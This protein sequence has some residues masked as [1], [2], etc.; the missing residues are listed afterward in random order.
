M[1]PLS[2][3]LFF[4][5]YVATYIEILC[6]RRYL[7]LDFL[8]TVTTIRST[9]C[10]R[11]RLILQID[12]EI[13]P[14]GPTASSTTTA[15]SSS[16]SSLPIILKEFD[17]I[18][19]REYVEATDKDQVIQIFVDGMLYAASFATTKALKAPQIFLPILSWAAVV[20]SKVFSITASRRQSSSSS[21]ST[22]NIFYPF[23]S[24]AVFG[25]LLP[26]G[27]IHGYIQHEWRNYIKWSLG[28][29][30]ANIDTVYKDKGGCFLVAVDRR[31]P[32]RIL[33]TLGGEIKDQA[34]FSEDGCLSVGHDH[35]APSSTT[36]SCSS[37]EKKSGESHGD[38][39]K[40]K[41]VELRRMS[42]DISCH[43]GGIG[44]RLVEFMHNRL[45][46][47]VAFL[48]CS[49]VQYGAHRLYEKAGYVRSDK[50]PGLRKHV[51]GTI[52]IWGYKKEFHPQK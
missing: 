6:S 7:S 26:I 28:S 25:F 4:T 9:Y 44:R 2:P 37:A 8:A 24:T 18:L 31:S 48:T 5:P 12:R 38:I 34:S 3:P 29:D 36:G 13:M 45:K 11:F 32:S 35:K 23:L 16:S 30:L 43:K 41:V 42:V 52:Q 33:G 39:K 50:I 20:G 51:L 15:G 10:E 49:N 47:D 27:G 14:Q 46:P 22:F 1:T 19:I 40:Q 21:A 17:D